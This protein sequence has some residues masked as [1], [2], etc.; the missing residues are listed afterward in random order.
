M[1]TGRPRRWD[2]PEDLQKQVDP[3]FQDCEDRG[4]YPPIAGLAYYCKVDRHTI[5]NYK[6]KDEYFHIVKR[7]R[8]YIEMELEQFIMQKGNVGSIFIAKQYGYKDRQEIDH[9]SN[10]I[11]D[12]TKAF[13]DAVKE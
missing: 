6:N 12:A 11:I 4:R 9:S 5:Y 1:P 2:T 3:Y 10:D 8:E 7:A 13:L